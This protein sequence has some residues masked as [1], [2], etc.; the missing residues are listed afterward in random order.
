[1]HDPKD[2]SGKNSQIK[3]NGSESNSLENSSIV[4]KSMHGI[5]IKEEAKTQEMQKPSKIEP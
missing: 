5:I 1:M 4:E 2:P 3:K